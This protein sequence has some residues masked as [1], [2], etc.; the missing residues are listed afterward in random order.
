VGRRPAQRSTTYEILRP[1]DGQEEPLDIL[2]SVELK[3]DSFG[4]HR[5]PELSSSKMKVEST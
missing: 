5:Q 2:D 4:S 3:G 1:L